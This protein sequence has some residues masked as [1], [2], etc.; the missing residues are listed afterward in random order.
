[1]ERRLM[2]NGTTNAAAALHQ[3]WSCQ[4]DVALTDTFCRHC[5]MRLAHEGSGAA[6]QPNSSS[7]IIHARLV[8][9]E[10]LLLKT[11]FGIVAL[12]LL[13]GWIALQMHHFGRE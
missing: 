6:E 12:L 5:G 10:K 7:A 9:I 11:I 1:M 13:V 8:S 3:C 2:T 4:G